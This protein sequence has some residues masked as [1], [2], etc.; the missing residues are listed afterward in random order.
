M[1]FGSL[2]FVFEV[3][4]YVGLGLP[5][6]NL[7]L[8]LISGAVQSGLETEAEFDGSFEADM[9][10][11]VDLDVSADL[12][13]NSDIE[14]EMDLGDGPGGGEISSGGISKG[15]FVR[16]NIYCLCLSLV[17]M[18]ALGIFAVNNFDGMVQWVVLLSS[19]AFAILIY[20]LFYRFVIYPLKINDAEALQAKNLKYRHAIVIFR[21]LQD[22][23]GKIQTKDAVGAVITYQ[24]RLDPDIC[25]E[26]RID[27]NEEVVITDIDKENTLCYV[28]LARHKI[29]EYSR[30]LMNK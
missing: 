10:V 20:I 7:L 18:G 15:F 25:K 2:A 23:P 14:W 12:E 28:T 4:I 13:I 5:L 22:S 19:A 30:K 27:E 1:Y 8:G 6:V 26:A 3:M 29:L 21:I 24:A 11:D 9:D 17:V 16:F